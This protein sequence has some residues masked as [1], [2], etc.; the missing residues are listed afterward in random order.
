MTGNMLFI[1][2]IGAGPMS[3]NWWLTKRSAPAEK[4]TLFGQAG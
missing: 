3:L 4:P 1:V 2:S